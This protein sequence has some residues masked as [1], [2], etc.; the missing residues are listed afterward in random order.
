[1]TP[2]GHR[3]RRLPAP[4]HA[5]WSDLVEPARTGPRVWLALLADE[6]APRVVE[7]ERPTRVVWSS[8]WPSRPDDRVVL[9]LAPHGGGTALTFTLLAAGEPPEQ[10]RTGHL[11]KRVNEL[12]YR[13][14]QLSYGQ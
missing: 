13:D 9:E 11:R 1:M 2:Y 8:L 12:L 6:V 7:S 4:P 14:L 5:V 10:S 3:T